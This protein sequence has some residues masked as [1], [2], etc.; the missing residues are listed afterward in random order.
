MRLE[1]TYYSAAS[2]MVWMEML[3]VGIQYVVPS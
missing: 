3:P 2:A 1:A